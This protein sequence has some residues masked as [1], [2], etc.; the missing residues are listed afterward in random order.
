MGDHNIKVPLYKNYLAIF[1][2]SG[3]IP[4][5]NTWFINIVNDLIIAGSIIFINLEEIL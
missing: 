3:K 5:F 2:S 1:N 4:V